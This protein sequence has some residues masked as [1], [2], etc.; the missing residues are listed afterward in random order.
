MGFLDT[1]AS[2]I[3]FSGSADAE[4][5]TKDEAENE[6]TKEDAEEEETSEESKG[7]EEEEEEEEDEDE[8]VDPAEAIREGGF[9]R[10]KRLKCLTPLQ[11]AQVQRNASPQSTTMMNALRESRSRLRSLASRRKTASKSVRALFDCEM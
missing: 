5:P 6:V 8:V 7:E 9:A 11:N 1:I 4:A 2:F 10:T 3:P